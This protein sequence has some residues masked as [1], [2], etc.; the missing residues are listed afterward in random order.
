MLT[1]DVG[2]NDFQLRKIH[3]TPLGLN[4]AIFFEEINTHSL[5][6]AEGPAA[7]CQAALQRPLTP[8]TIRTAQDE[9][10]Q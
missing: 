9:L 6:K 4:S 1:A 10:S 3:D 2:P 7:Q 5:S 8:V